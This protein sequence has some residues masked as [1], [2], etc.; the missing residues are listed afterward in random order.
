MIPETDLWAF[1]APF[2]A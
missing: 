1:R 2:T